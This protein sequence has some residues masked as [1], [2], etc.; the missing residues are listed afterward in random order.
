MAADESKV[1]GPSVSTAGARKQDDVRFRLLTIRQRMIK[2][3]QLGRRGRVMQRRA[4]SGKL[5]VSDES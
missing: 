4:V 2:A 5:R 1:R 3:L